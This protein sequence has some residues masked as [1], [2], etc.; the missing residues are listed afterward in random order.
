M[1]LAK[2]HGT[3]IIGANAEDASCNPDE[4]FDRIRLGRQRRRGRPR[5]GYCDTLGL[6]SPLGIYDFG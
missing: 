3:R 2:K 6:D 4:L 1:A 5:P